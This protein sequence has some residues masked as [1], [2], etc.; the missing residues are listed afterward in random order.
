MAQAP[1]RYFSRRDQV[2]RGEHRDRQK[3]PLYS[4]QLS[5]PLTGG[6]AQRERHN[7]TTDLEPLIAHRATAAY[8]PADLQWQ[9]ALYPRVTAYDSG[10][11]TDERLFRPFRGGRQ[12]LPQVWGHTARAQR[13][14]ASLSPL[15]AEGLRKLFER[16]VQRHLDADTQVLIFVEEEEP[17]VLAWARENPAWRV[18]PAYTRPPPAVGDPEP[19]PPLAV[20]RI[21]PAEPAPSP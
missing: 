13:I 9:V 16:Q 10:A 5:D 7:P 19:L 6:F 4:Y 17:A 3:F 21:R 1:P 20:W 14:H 12:F 8:A 2:T 15:G 11:W 18:E